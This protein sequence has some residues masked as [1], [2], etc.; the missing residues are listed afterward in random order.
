MSLMGYSEQEIKDIIKVCYT[1]GASPS[2]YVNREQKT[3]LEIAGD[4][5]D[6]LVEEGRV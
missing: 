1:L 5:L 2:S 4:I 6:G 3:S